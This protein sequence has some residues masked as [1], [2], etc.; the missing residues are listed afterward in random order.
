MRLKALMSWIMVL[1][2]G[3]ADGGWAIAAFFRLVNVVLSARVGSWGCP[4][5]RGQSAL[6]NN[7]QVIEDAEE[8]VGQHGIVADARDM[9][10][11]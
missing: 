7:C 5:G 2:V 11:L 6:I 3:P 10:Y 1:W 8:I 4:G 9:V